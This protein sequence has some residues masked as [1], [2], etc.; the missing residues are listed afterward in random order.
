MNYNLVFLFF[1]TTHLI[2]VQILYVVFENERY[3]VNEQKTIN[4]KE[5]YTDVL[6]TMLYIIRFSS[7]FFVKSVVYF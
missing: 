2:R 4:P 1:V 3:Y 6:K 5:S 7:V